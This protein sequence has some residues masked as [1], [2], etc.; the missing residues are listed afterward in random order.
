M[1][2]EATTDPRGR[3]PSEP[4]EKRSF[5]RVVGVWGAIVVDRP[6]E[7]RSEAQGNE[8]AD[9]GACRRDP[10]H[11]RGARLDA[12]RGPVAAERSRE[13]A[14]VR[15]ATRASARRR[16][17]EDAGA[18]S[19]KG[20]EVP[21]RPVQKGIA[22]ARRERGHVRGEQMGH[23]L[24]M[25]PGAPPRHCKILCT[26]GPASQSPEI[27]GALIDAGMDAVRL[28]LS[29]GT[30]EEH[31]RVYRAVRRE[32][33]RRNVAIA[34]LADLQGPKLR[35]GKIPGEGFQLEEGDKV[36]ISIR[37]DAPVERTDELTRVTA[38][39]ER[40]T[41]DV[42]PGDRILLDDGNIELTA[43]GVDGDVLMTTVVQGGLL[44]SNK[45]INLPGVELQV[46]A[47][48]EKDCRDLSFALDLGVDAVALSFVRRPE[49]VEQ[50]RQRMRDH[51][52]V[53]PIIAKIEKP[54]AIDNLD[55]I[56]DAADGIMI[57]RGDLGV[58]MGP[59]AVPIIQK[60]AIEKANRRGKLVITATQM[61]DSMIRKPRPTRAEASDVANAVLDGSDTVM[62]SGE[63]ATGL[64]PV[65]AVR[66][67]DKIVRTTE[68]APRAWN[69]DRSDLALGHTT[70]AIARAAVHAS[71]SWPDTKAIITYT[72]TGGIARLVSEYRPRVP[73][74][75]FTPN[76][77]TYQALALYWGVCPVLFSPSSDDGETMFIDMDQ[78]ILRRGFL[79]PG[80]RIVI[81]FG[82][83]IKSRSSVNLLKL[84]Q[85]GE[86]L[87]GPL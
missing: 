56:I 44:S 8:E 74:Y 59:E 63:T 62:L 11:A 57:A 38:T 21:P 86:T 51:G 17:R 9:R 49:D 31:T 24:V 85:V 77:D 70:N 72:G 78:A 14:D 33:S 83:P 61:L 7:T 64:H 47:M 60:R 27:I 10:G 29:H 16:G 4:A 23:A 87:S 18:G 42:K 46:P 55:A 84:H 41:E 82:H 26:I 79:D 22:G 20:G 30:H 45:G 13:G 80:A 67:M 2:G 53:R 65:L 75:A 54:Q 35:V 73:I 15:S 76:P 19:T 58:E 50:C 66:T 34:I 25:R 6:H 81:T 39:Y 5:V 43:N 32:A 71:E 1:D 3:R 68:Q 12:G 36:A 40:L 28:N 37:P 48:T 69:Q 52:R